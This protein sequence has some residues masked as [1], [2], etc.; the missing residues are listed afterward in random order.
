MCNNVSNNAI[1]LAEV[2]DQD[3][4][5]NRVRIAD[6]NSRLLL[7]LSRALAVIK[8]MFQELLKGR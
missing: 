4:A 3:K 7:R 5:N 2:I 1:T 6:S 8:A